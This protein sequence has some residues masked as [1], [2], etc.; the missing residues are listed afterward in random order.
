MVYF[1]FRTQRVVQFVVS[2]N[3]PSLYVLKI[4]YVEMFFNME[5]NTSTSRYSKIEYFKNFVVE[6]VKQ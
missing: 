3:V 2:L 1:I 4:E 5:N 6:Y